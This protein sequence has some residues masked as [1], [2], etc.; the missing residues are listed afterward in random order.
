M[1]K[2][3]D[4][5]GPLISDD[6]YQVVKRV[7]KKDEIIHKH[8]HPDVKIVFVVVKGCVVMTIDNADFVVVPGQVLSIDGKSTI[9]GTFKEDSEVVVT[10][11]KKF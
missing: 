3:L 1:A 2:L 7:G 8:N 9:S 6:R 4:K 11:V 5:A 10:F